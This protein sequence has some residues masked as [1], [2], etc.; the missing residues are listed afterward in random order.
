MSLEL[1]ARKAVQKLVP[2]QSARRIGGKGDVWINANEAPTSHPYV[3]DASRLNRYPECQP[4]R[5]IQGYADYAGLRADQVLVSRGADEG[6]ELLIR[7]FCEPGQDR[8]AQCT[9]TY[10]MYSISAETCGVKV[11]DVPLGKKFA[12]DYSELAELSSKVKLIFL[13]APNNPTGH[14]LDTA[15]LCN[16]LK[17]RAGKSLVV[18]DEAYIEFCAEHSVKSLL[19]EFDNLVILR[20]LSKAFALAGIRCGF[21][22]AN[23][24]VIELLTKVIAPYPVPEPVV[25][26]ATQALSGEGVAR[27]RASVD[28]LKRLRGEFGDKLARL[29]C[30]KGMFPATG[31]YLLV[32]FADAD[33][34]FAKLVSCGIIARDFSK[35][36]RLEGCIR[37]TIGTEQEMLRTLEALSQ[38]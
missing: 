5:V 35:K 32:Q 1:L 27:M 31:N 38:L 36:P 23:P 34:A 18:V 17:A 19:D 3:L 8:I 26:I 21:T 16:L 7:T 25:Q 33:A 30:V 28:T 2:Y 15:K 4:P 29:D 20:T 22:L 11:V 6:I 14:M 24:T 13:C 12:I 37:F 10:G 9:P